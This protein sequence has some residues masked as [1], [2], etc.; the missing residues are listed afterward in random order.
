MKTKRIFLLA[1][2]LALVVAASAPPVAF[3]D[4][5]VVPFKGTYHGIPVGR[6]D[7]TCMC[8]RQTFE[9]DGNATHLGNSHFSATGTVYQGPPMLQFGGGTFISA[10]GDLL[11]WSFEGTGNFLPDGLVEFWGEF[12]ITGGTGR[13]EG[14]TGEGTYWGMATAAP[15]ANPWGKITF[16]GTLYK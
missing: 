4:D 13:F 8:V 2:I 9:F 10:D 5:A 3:A 1:L 16:D 7:P 14:V 11:Y 6:F 12:W 15:S